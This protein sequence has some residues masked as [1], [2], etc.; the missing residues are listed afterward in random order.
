MSNQSRRI[1]GGRALLLAQGSKLQYRVFRCAAD[2]FDEVFIL[3]TPEA[4]ILRLSL[5][6]AGFF[7]FF[8]SFKAIETTIVSEINA[9]CERLSIDCVLPSCSATTRFLASYGA[10]L[11][12]PHYPIPSPEAFDILDDKWR[13]AGICADL[14][15]PH[16]RT[17]CFATGADLLAAA[18][19]GRLTY[20]LIIKPLGMSG[21]SGVRKIDAAADLPSDAGYEPIL[22]QDY[23]PGSEICAFFLCRG[24][25]IVSSIA[26]IGNSRGITF[27]CDEQID[28][29]VKVIVE[30]FDYHGVV[31]FDVVRSRSGDAFFIECNPRF[32]YRMDLALVA[33]LNFV[34]LGCSS[35]FEA[36]GPPQTLR[37]IAVPS[38]R[39]LVRVM[40]AP[41]RMSR[42]DRGAFKLLFHDP[43]PSILLAAWSPRR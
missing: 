41:W 14:G 18:A 33:G 24:G 38:R 34:K 43:L 26:Y 28:R 39:G 2:Y 25:K 15:I 16:P 17:E 20:P 27:V 23:V 8:G 6:C 13:F 7:P 11:V 5:L 32:W 40:L 37:D 12:S 4:S 19:H 42:Y 36:D 22:V 30:H 21:S 3:G 1:R 10:H 35:E 31:G 9:L 29:D